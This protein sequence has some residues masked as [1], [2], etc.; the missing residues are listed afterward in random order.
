M[1][2]HSKNWPKNNHELTLELFC[3]VYEE[4]R[5]Y[6]EELGQSYSPIAELSKESIS[7]VEAAIVSVNF[8][9][10]EGVQHYKPGCEA[11]AAYLYFIN[12]S[13]FLFN[14]N[15]RASLAALFGYLGI[16]DKY[17][18]TDW[19]EIYKLATKIALSDPKDVKKVINQISRTICASLID[20]EDNSIQRFK[21]SVTNW[22]K[23]YS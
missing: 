17:L 13:H 2:L 12:K 23:N 11:A 10:K 16:K 5:D 6:F 8:K 3:K 22:V 9:S 19:K 4:Y 1:T 18:K 15:K 21:I 7:K 20:M 14:G